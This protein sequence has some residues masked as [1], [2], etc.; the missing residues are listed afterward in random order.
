M[1]AA[2]G[3]DLPLVQKASGVWREMTEIS[4]FVQPP[5]KGQRWHLAIALRLVTPCP[6]PAAQSGLPHGLNQGT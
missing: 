4:Y 1:H 2:I 5:E 6:G 3:C